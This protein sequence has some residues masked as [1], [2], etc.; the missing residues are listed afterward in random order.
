MYNYNHL[1]YFYITVRSGG[2]TPAAKHLLISQP[3]LSGQIK[4]LETYLQ[5]KLFRKVGRRNQL[6]PEGTTIYGFC[7]QMFEA[8]K[9]MQESIEEQTCDS[10]R[11]ITIGVSDEISGSLIGDIVSHFLAKF[12]KNKCPRVTI[13]SE[14]HNLLKEKLK[15]RE[16]DILISPI[17]IRGTEI[18]V[19]N[20]SDIPVVLL[21]NQEIQPTIKSDSINSS[22][23]KT[24]QTIDSSL[25]LVMPTSGHKLERETKEFLD[26]NKIKNKVILESNITESIVK[27]TLDGIGMAFLPSIYVNKHINKNSLYLHGPREGFWKYKVYLSCQ[28]NKSL[29]PLLISLSNSF[30]EI[31][32]R[33][34]L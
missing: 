2:F 27:L 32:N 22:L 26:Q 16:V 5:I 12:K 17:S 4:V 25:Q 13:T 7:S 28:T 6:T 33:H 10:S 8:S 15:F 11:N 18:S 29:D 9:D 21:S 3:S 31:C 1:Y 34:G 24:N 23:K 30:T 20:C 14:S 19:I